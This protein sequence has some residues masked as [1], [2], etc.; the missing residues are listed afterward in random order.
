MEASSN[1]YAYKYRHG[2]FG[3]ELVNSL[4]IIAN[5][6]V[7]PRIFDC[8]RCTRTTF[9][10][11]LPRLLYLTIFHSTA[12]HANIYVHKLASFQLGKINLHDKKKKMEKKGTEK[13]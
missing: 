12:Y 9:D 7:V 2:A 4:R 10:Y 6:V 1:E 5:S 3:C 13:S 11:L 8:I